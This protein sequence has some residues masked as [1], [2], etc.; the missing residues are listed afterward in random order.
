M[1]LSTKQL[2]ELET[3]TSGAL[4]FDEEGEEG[5]IVDEGTESALA[6]RRGMIERALNNVKKAQKKSLES[7]SVSHKVGALVYDE[8]VKRFGR[9]TKVEGKAV[10]L[11][12]I[13]GGES[14]I[15]P[16]H[17]API[18]KTTKPQPKAQVTP[19]APAAQK[20]A[21]VKLKKPLPKPAPKKPVAST[22]ARS[23]LRKPKPAIKVDTKKANKRYAAGQTSDANTYIKQHFMSMSNKE[24]AKVTG[25]SEHTIRRKLGEWGMRRA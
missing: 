2:E 22:P 12:L 23:S 25:L 8:Q 9:V 20:P 4:E 6:W 7:E 17:A 19:K 10:H 13:A 11:A 1:I 21:V 5:E 18:E 3:L 14:T 15:A 16:H 24:L